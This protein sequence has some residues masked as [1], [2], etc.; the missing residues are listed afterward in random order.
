[1]TAAPSGESQ[2]GHAA[3]LKFPG[4]R[5]ERVLPGPSTRVW[6]HLVRPG[7]LPNWFGEKSSIEPRVGGAVNF[8]DGHIR[9]TVT[10]CSPPDYLTYTWN[11]FSP[12]DGPDAVSAYPESYLTLALEPRQDAVLLR[13]QHLPVLE[14]F[15]RQNAMGW[16]TFLDI[17]HDTLTGLPARPRQDYMT[18]NAALYGVDL[19]NLQR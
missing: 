5:F 15:E 11:V 4:V 16:A 14:C 1:M 8:M 9:G 13:L 6:E 17:L 12:G 7:L 19:N 3:F 18:R 10:R 2:A